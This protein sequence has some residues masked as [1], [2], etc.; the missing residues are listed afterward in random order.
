MKPSGS[1]CDKPQGP[2]FWERHIQE[3]NRSGLSQSNYCRKEG[4][5][6]HAFLYWRRRLNQRPGSQSSRQSI[7]LVQLEIPEPVMSAPVSDYSHSGV[8]LEMNG[9]YVNLM[10]DF[11]QRTLL[12]VIQVLREPGCG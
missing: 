10:S 7:N 2:E 8:Q 12:R 1:L 6:Y 3:W 4:L 11:D 9:L 5:R